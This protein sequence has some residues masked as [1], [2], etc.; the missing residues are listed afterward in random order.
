MKN[1]EEIGFCKLICLA[2]LALGAGFLAF[3]FQHI[4]K[5]SHIHLSLSHSHRATAFCAFAGCKFHEDLE[6]PP[7]VVPETA[8]SSPPSVAP[9]DAPAA[10]Q[11]TILALKS[12]VCGSPAIDGY[13]HVVPQCL[14]D[15]PTAKWWKK[16]YG[17]GGKQLDLVVHIEKG[18]DYDGLAVAWGLGNKKKSAAECAQQC[19]EHMPGK[20]DGP[21]KNLPCNAFS[22]CPDEVCFVPDAHKHTKGDCWIKFTEGPAYPEINMRGDLPPEFRL[23]HPNAP[24]T[25]QWWGGVI[26]PRGVEPTNGTFGPRWQ[27]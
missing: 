1:R 21:F 24:N 23:R 17:S 19:L 22:W 8:R 15:S 4:M 16:Y 2:V 13:I 25:T 26:L 5:V 18:A 7:K 10:S 14:E 27:W 11:E 3:N 9:S 12:R 20:V 6:D